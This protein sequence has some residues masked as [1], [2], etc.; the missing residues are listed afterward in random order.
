MAKKAKRKSKSKNLND[1]NPISLGDDGPFVDF[2]IPQENLQDDIKISIE[3][4]L[5]D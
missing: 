1:K 4:E 5:L 2:K 3:I